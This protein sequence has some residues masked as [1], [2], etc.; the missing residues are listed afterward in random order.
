[1]AQMPTGIKLVSEAGDHY[2]NLYGGGKA[3]TCKTGT[4][5]H[6]SKCRWSAKGDRWLA[7]KDGQLKLDVAK[8]SACARTCAKADEG[9]CLVAAASGGAGTA[10]WEIAPAGGSWE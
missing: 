9:G 3:G 2:L 4:A 8:G 5:I 10:G 7:I 6:S 1:M